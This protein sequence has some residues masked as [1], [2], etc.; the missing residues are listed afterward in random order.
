MTI[1]PSD[2]HLHPQLPSGSGAPARVRSAA[3]ALSRED[4]RELACAAYVY[5]YPLVLTDIGRQTMTSVTRAGEWCAPVNQFAHA[6]TFPGSLPAHVNPEA[7]T[8]ASAAWLDLGS[9][10]IILTVPDVGR[11]YF[12][13]QLTDAWTHVIGSIGTRATG[14][15]QYTIALVGPAWTGTLPPAVKSIRST[16]RTVR[17]T[18]RIQT[19]GISDYPAVRRLQQELRLLPLPPFVDGAGQAVP[20][21]PVAIDSPMDPVERAAGLSAEEFFVR[22][23]R[24]L[25][26]NPPFEGDDALLRRLKVIGVGP[27]TRFNG[28]RNLPLLA[29]GLDEGV[30]DARERISAGARI[31]GGVQA[32]SWYV[33]PRSSGWSGRD[34]MTRAIVARLNLGVPGTNEDLAV[35]LG[36]RDAHGERLS[37]DHRY[38]L[39]LGANRLPPAYAFWSITMRTGS[40]G[41][42]ANRLERFAIGDA[43]H[44][45]FNIDG[46]LTLRVQ[47]MSPGVRHETNWL[48]SPAG[49]FSLVLRIYWPT[50]D[51]LDG[52]WTPP[53]IERLQDIR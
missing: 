35:A 16:T 6:R 18:C 7:G 14:N 20:H 8:L 12:L 41:F 46:S 37:G 33:L 22:L 29:R 39:R 44:L 52:R 28:L 23:N 42:V 4:V 2:S 53:P 17:I 1:R 30:R 40:G 51:V 45:A 48:P 3:V 47:R 15:G 24:L 50:A 36:T 19:H 25:N 5:G 9:D 34:H 38:V 13:L 43:D 49:H 11:R 10:P 26:E 31:L 27:S 32:A 21:R